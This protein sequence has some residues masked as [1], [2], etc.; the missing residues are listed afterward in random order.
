MEKEINLFWANAEELSVQIPEMWVWIDVVRWS[1]RLDTPSCSDPLGK[2]EGRE[3]SSKPLESSKVCS[4]DAW[5]RSWVKFSHVY[6][7]FHSQSVTWPWIGLERGQWL[8]PGAIRAVGWKS[9]C[10]LF[11]CPHHHY[12]GYVQAQGSSEGALSLH[13]GLGHS[14]LPLLSAQSSFWGCAE[15]LHAEEREASNPTTADHFRDSCEETEFWNWF[16]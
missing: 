10:W 13:L 15:Y 8:F 7:P 11:I 3:G 1:Q 2:S 4:W 14:I 6:F 16:L 5:M 9:S 12:Q